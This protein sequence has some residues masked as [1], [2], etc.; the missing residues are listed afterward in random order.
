M[1]SFGHQLESIDI[2]TVMTFFCKSCV[3]SMVFLNFL[4]ETSIAHL[5]LEVIF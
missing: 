2:V 3:N 4:P 1:V 5:D